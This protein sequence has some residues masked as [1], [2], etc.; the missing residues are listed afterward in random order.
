MPSNPISECYRILALC[1]EGYTW[2][3]LYTSRVSGIQ[4]PN[5]SEYPSH[6]SIHVTP[7]SIAIYQITQSLPYHTNQF[8]IYMDNYFTNIPLFQV[9][10]ELGIGACGT[11]RENKNAFPPEFHNSFPGLP[12]NHLCDAEVGCISDPVLALQW[13]DRVSVHLLS[14]IRQITD[15]VNHKL[16]KPRATSTNATTTCHA[17]APGRQKEILPIPLIIDDYTHSMNGVDPADHLCASYPTQLKALRNWLPLLFWILDTSI[18]NSFLLYQF[19]HPNA[20][21]CQF[22]LDVVTGLFNNSQP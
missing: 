15:F 3:W 21:H 18:V 13:E 2:N 16:N 1:W 7:T 14:T 11:A 4:L 22:N 9:L 8:N 6:S 20:K 19:T 12:W 17:F 5:A 10:R